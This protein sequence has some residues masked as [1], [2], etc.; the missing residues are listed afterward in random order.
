MGR[1]IFWTTT[2]ELWAFSCN[3]SPLVFLF[4]MVEIIV[5][6]HN[7]TCFLPHNSLRVC[8]RIMIKRQ[9]VSRLVAASSQTGARA[10]LHQ[11]VF[12]CHAGRLFLHIRQYVHVASRIL[13]LNLCTRVGTTGT[14]LKALGPNFQSEACVFRERAMGAKTQW[15]TCI[16]HIVLVALEVPLVEEPCMGP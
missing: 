11:P 3:L 4:H 8:P 1:K 15:K 9:R 5:P 10:M 6:I 12:Y 7:V 13:Y 2:R 16:V 14:I